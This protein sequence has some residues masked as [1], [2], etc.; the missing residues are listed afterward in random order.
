MKKIIVFSVVFVLCAQLLSCN[1]SN[2][3]LTSDN[4]SKDFVTGF[5]DNYRLVD[6]QLAYVTAS[7]WEVEIKVNN[8]ERLYLS[9]ID[10]VDK[11]QFVSVTERHDYYMDPPSY[12][13]FVYQAPD[14]PT[15]MKDWTVKRVRVLEVT[16]IADTKEDAVSFSEKYTEALLGSSDVLYTY[17]N[18]NG[19]DFLD[20]IKSAYL[21]AETLQSHPGMIRGTDS[22]QPDYLRYYSLLI[23][24]NENDNIVWH[25]YLFEDSDDIYF[26]CTAYSA[27]DVD[28][29]GFS[30]A[31]ISDEFAE[32]V[33]RIIDKLS[34]T[35]L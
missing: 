14:A 6:P 10:D 29:N 23:E 18:D 13:L 26:E 32:E 8:D 25:S 2:L 27:D 21:A 24:F 1:S 33:R 16:P 15:P 22:D 3:P 31:K 7:P 34:N 9:L 30:M 4:F 35:G 5:S 12:R 19:S 28:R 20:M 17:D 11:A